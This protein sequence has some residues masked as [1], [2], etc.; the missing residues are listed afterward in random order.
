METHRRVRGSVD[1]NR[2]Q[3]VLKKLDID[4]GVPKSSTVLDDIVFKMLVSDAAG[5]KRTMKTKA[6]VSSAYTNAKTTR[7]KRFL[8]CPATC[9]QFDEDGTPLV[10]ELGPPL[11]GEPEA[12]YE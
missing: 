11:F 1:G 4:Y 8:R 2:G 10:L 3:Y 9:Q 5:R 12:G 6:D 7:G